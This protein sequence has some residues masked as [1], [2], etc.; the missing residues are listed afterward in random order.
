MTSTFTQSEAVSTFTMVTLDTAILKNASREII[1]NY[2][3]ACI[4]VSIETFA[5]SLGFKIEYRDIR[6]LKNGY[7]E[8]AH[9][10]IVVNTNI[11]EINQRVVIAKEIGRLILLHAN[12]IENY[13]HVTTIM[14]DDV[15]RALDQF[16]MDLL[17]PAVVLT[18]LV[19]RRKIRSSVYLRTILNV[20]S[21]MLYVRLQQL[22]YFL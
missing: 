1:D 3:D 17:I 18:I 15:E 14:H 13:D 2:W 20:S 21:S 8:L 7:C 16:V 6:T 11:D 4:P 5:Q 19:D 9:N 10:R 12:H 22:G